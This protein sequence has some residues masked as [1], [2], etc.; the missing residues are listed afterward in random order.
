MIRFLGPVFF[1]TVNFIVALAG[2]G[3]GV[4]F[5]GE[6]HSHWVWLALLCLL[7]GVFFVIQRRRER[8]ERAGAAPG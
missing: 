8:P 3:W 2:I 1:S 7:A 6:S 5:F 4:L